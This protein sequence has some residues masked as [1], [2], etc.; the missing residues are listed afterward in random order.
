MDKNTHLHY[1][2]NLS[3]TIDLESLNLMDSQN[4]DIQDLRI[5]RM[6]ILSELG[7]LD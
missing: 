2:E 3:D 1:A 4:Q 7:C 6:L 5:D